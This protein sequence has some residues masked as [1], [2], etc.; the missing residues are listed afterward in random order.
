MNLGLTDIDVWTITIVYDNNDV[1]QLSI[2]RNINLPVQVVY[3][4]TYKYGI[5]VASSVYAEFGIIYV[6]LKDGSVI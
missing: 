1:I 3:K 2:P 5:T 4:N 6:C